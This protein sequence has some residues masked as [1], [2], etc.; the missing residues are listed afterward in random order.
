MRRH[1]VR[2]RFYFHLTFFCPDRIGR[3][4][5]PATKQKTPLITAGFFKSGGDDGGPALKE[6]FDRCYESFFFRLANAIAALP[7]L[8]S[9]IVAGSGTVLCP[10]E[11]PYALTP[12][13]IPSFSA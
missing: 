12:M 8:N 11:L 3:R 4:V 7:M 13:L 6:L 5:F 1:R 2:G 10:Y 9:S